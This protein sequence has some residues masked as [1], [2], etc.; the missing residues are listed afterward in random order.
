MTEVEAENMG[1]KNSKHVLKDLDVTTL[2]CAYT[3]LY[4]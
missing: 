2:C 3:V 4:V 1:K